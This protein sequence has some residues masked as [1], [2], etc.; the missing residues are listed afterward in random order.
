M[1]IVI[2]DYDVGNLR[3]VQKAFERVGASAVVSR[4]PA[5]IKDA[6]AL[7]LP[8]V[9]AFAECMGNLE[10][11][12][13]TGPVKDFIASGRPFLG[14]CVGYQMLFEQSEEFGSCKGLG[15]F[16]GR[17]V[18]FGFKPSPGHKI[19]HMGWNQVN[20]RNKGKLF[21]GIADGTDF[22]F[23]H[24]Y[25]P[26]PEDGIVT[27]MTEYGETFASSIESG[28]VFATQFHPEK[29]QNAGL[30]LLRNFTKLAGG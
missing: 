6:T 2:A 23:V 28:N 25:Y 13:L 11:Y 21:E 30:A 15:I 20:F 22:Y 8:G 29:S 26:V 3:S 19:P 18:R 24:S 4:S 10:K 5:G 7:V 27:G 1:P 12:G 9:G 16:R 14:I 17:C